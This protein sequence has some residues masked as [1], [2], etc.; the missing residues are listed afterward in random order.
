MVAIINNHLDFAIARERHWYRVPVSSKE[1]WLK[2][3]WPP[4]WLAL[5]QT[6][7]F[8]EEAHAVNYYARVR[9]VRRVYRWQLFPDEPRDERSN[10]EYYQLFFEPLTR[11]SSPVLSHRRRRIIFIPTTW[12]KFVTATEINDL[13][14]ESS[15]EDRLWKEFKRLQVHAERQALVTIKDRSYFLDFAI[16]CASG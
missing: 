7:E 10:R 6:K 2:D 9:E 14:D 8:D 11:L 1:K 16:C 12:R 5:Y 3:R 4:K 15:L 13:Y